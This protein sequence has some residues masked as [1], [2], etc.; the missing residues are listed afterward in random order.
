MDDAFLAKLKALL[1]EYE[2]EI[3]AEVGDGSDTHGIHG[4]EMVITIG[5][6]TVL[7]VRGWGLSAREIDR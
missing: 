2:A 6:E 3:S 1:T 7:R 4:E 5:R